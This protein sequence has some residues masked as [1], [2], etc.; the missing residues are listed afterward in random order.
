MA[1]CI[2]DVSAASFAR[3]AECTADFWARSSRDLRF[4]RWDSVRVIQC[5]LTEKC[6]Y[7]MQ[8]S[9]GKGGYRE[10]AED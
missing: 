8:C 3:D 2:S 7:T 1:A 10:V 4:C 9:R 5:E 6:V